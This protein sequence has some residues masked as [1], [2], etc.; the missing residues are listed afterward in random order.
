MVLYYKASQRKLD[1]IAKEEKE[2]EEAKRKEKQD[3][4]D[5]CELANKPPD[6]REEPAF[7]KEEDGDYEEYHREGEDKE[8][9]EEEEES[10]EAAEEGNPLK[11]SESRKVTT[12]KAGSSGDELGLRCPGFQDWPCQGYTSTRVEARLCGG[13]GYENGKGLAKGNDRCRQVPLHNDCLFLEPRSLTLCVAL[14]H[15]PLSTVSPH[16]SP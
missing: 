2:M 4:K 10:S 1:E 14:S 15:L 9:N 5:L 16:S 3:K 13:H 11:L 7:V 6:H 8:D 12:A